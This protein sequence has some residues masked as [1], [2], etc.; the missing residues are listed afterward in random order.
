MLAIFMILSIIPSYQLFK[1]G[2]FLFFI[3]NDV[4]FINDDIC[5]SHKCICMSLWM[6]WPINNEKLMNLGNLGLLLLWL[7][8]FSF[9]SSMT[10][11]INDDINFKNNNISCS[12]KYRCKLFR[13]T[14]PISNKKQMNLN[15]WDLLYVACDKYSNSSFLS[16]TTKLSFIFYIIPIFSII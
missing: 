3:D 15:I 9:F 4:C 5:C 16:T 11:L 14:W 2:F 8:I 6:T 12:Y 10:S 1:L 13:I 7:C